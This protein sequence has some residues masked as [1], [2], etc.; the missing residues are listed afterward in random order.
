L[1]PG[2][3]KLKGFGSFYETNLLVNEPIGQN[4]LWNLFFPGRFL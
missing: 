3:E 2:V 4:L 1:S